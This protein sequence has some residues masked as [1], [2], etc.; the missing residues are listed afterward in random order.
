MYET[1]FVIYKPHLTDRQKRVAPFIGLKCCGLLG[2]LERNSSKAG[3]MSN[4]KFKITKTPPP[5]L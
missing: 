5:P 3:E 4:L 2:K 1:Y